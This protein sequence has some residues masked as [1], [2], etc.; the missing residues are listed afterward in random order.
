MKRG[1]D[2]K[3]H[4]LEH[5]EVGVGEFQLEGGGEVGGGGEGKGTNFSFVAPSSEEFSVR[6]GI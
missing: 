4:L 2:L 3:G 1:W 5:Q 6:K